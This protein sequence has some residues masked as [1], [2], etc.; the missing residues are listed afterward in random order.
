MDVLSYSNCGKMTDNSKSNQL[1]YLTTQIFLFDKENYQ[2]KILEEVSKIF[3][4]DACAYL[5]VVDYE[6]LF[7]SHFLPFESDVPNRIFFNFYKL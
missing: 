7:L 1:F 2:Q 3:S 6:N 5:N 4:F